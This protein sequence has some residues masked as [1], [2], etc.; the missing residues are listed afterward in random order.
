M[1]LCQWREQTCYGLPLPSGQ[2]VNL[3]LVGKGRQPEQ[4]C[5]GDKKR[6]RLNSGRAPEL[7]KAVLEYLLDER[8]AGCPVSNKDLQTK[9]LE[10]APQLSV[11]STF[12][13][14]NMW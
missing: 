7:D 14:S 3:Q 6:R 9:A 2:E 12:K 13:A 11:P 1:V 8:A 10:L 4:I 5:R